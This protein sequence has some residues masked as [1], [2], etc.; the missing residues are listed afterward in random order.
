[1]SSRS[2]HAEQPERPAAQD[3]AQ[4][5]DKSA[6]PAGPPEGF[7]R[8][9]FES[10]AIRDFRYLWLGSLLGMS[11]F[12]MQSFARTFL[13]DELT[14]SAF[15]T[16]IV[17]MGFAPTLLIF[18]LVGGV[19]GDRFERRAVIQYSQLGSAAITLTIAVLI[20]TQVIHWTHLLVASL[21]QGAS[22]S[23]QMPARQAVLPKVVGKER[24]S[25]AIALGSG[26]MNLTGVAVPGLAG[27][28]YTSFG[29][30]HGGAA[31]VYYVVGG[32]YL[33]TVFLTAQIPR[34]PP[35]ASGKSKNVVDDIA[36]GLRYVAGNRVVL[37]VLITTIFTALLAMPFRMQTPV[38]ARRL[39]ESDA[40]EVGWL[41]MVMALGGVIGT[42][43]IANLRQGNRRG[44]VYIAGTLI[45][46]V[47][48]ALVAAFPEYAIGL[49]LMILVGLGSSIRMTLGQSLTLE[50][51]DAEYRA[52]VMGLNMTVFGLLPLGALPVGAAVDLYGAEW[53]LLFVGAALLVVG[54][55]IL[56]GSPTL[57]KLG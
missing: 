25:N 47:S 13:V 18:S 11:G 29:G 45:S 48:I 36:A 5:P 24:L 33:F 2:K 32:M 26:G 39:Y 53:T 46:G 1:M 51:S 6:D 28:I 3:Q 35:E 23:F 8:R 10:L 30:F 20:S 17:G 34:M 7:L 27:L 49:P 22:F 55:V 38:F 40:S 31:A 4:Q 50:A 9:T 37:L 12:Q 14:G 54:A 16:S 52:R 15:I 21:L 42:I 41:M 43:V 57:R 19:V 56:L 44:I